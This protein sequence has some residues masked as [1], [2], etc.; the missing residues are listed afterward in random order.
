MSATRQ[1]GSFKN[2]L[3]VKEALC[4]WAEGTAMQFW[5][6]ET[7]A[8]PTEKW[9][10]DGQNARPGSDISQRLSSP[11]FYSQET[12]APGR[13]RLRVTPEPWRVLLTRSARLR[14]RLCPH[15]AGR[16]GEGD[17]H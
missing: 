3:L 7:E 14:P 17:F 5:E 6:A 11:S 4:E 1:R 2:L 9:V 12:E 10:A 15:Q 8:G 13:R 16:Q